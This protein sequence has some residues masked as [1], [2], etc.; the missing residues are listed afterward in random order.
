MPT[1]RPRTAKAATR[2]AT[3][4][5][6]ADRG[7]AGKWLSRTGPGSDNCPV[8]QPAPPPAAVIRAFNGE[9]GCLKPLPGGQGG[10]WRAG[11]VV[12]KP[13]GPHSAAPW[14]GPA[15]QNLPGGPGFRIARPL[16]SSGGTWTVQGWEATEWLA[17]RHEPGRWHDALD[18]SE[19]FHR[20]VREQVPD[21]PASIASD[22]PWGVGDRVAWREEDPGPLHPL[23]AAALT[24]LGP[25]LDEQWT[26]PA[27]QLI[28]GDL[29]VG[30]ILFADDLGLAPAVLDVSPYWRPA[31]FALAVLVA[32]ALAWEGAPPA[33][34]REFLARP[35]QPRQLLARA[36]AY[37]VVASAGL[38]PDA[39]DRVAAEI[40]GYHSVL[41]LLG[42]SSLT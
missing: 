5:G 20:A 3:G 24:R 9:P 32:D 17:G 26:G 1:G 2:T 13:T 22:S 27:A 42:I 34:G 38:W 28:H 37:R 6:S 30:N 36:I 19:A 8:S 31:A 12:L 29:G 18:V 35:G 11:G 23:A 4:R 25:L 16:A 41:A 15:L 7:L 39:P 10:S 14:L 33:L 40:A 21:R